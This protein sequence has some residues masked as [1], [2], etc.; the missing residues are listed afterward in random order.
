[1]K[2]VYIIIPGIHTDPADWRN[3]APRMTTAIN[4]RCEDAKADEFR[5]YAL[6]ITPKSRQTE[7]VRYVV[8]LSL[9]YH[10]AGFAV[11]LVAHSNGAII[12]TEAAKIAPAIF[13][14]MHLIAA[15]CDS[16]FSFNGLNAALEK[17]R[18][19]SVCVYTGKKDWVL[20]WMAAAGAWLG[21]G[22]LGYYGPTNVMPHVKHKVSTV[23]SDFGHCGWFRDDQFEATLALVTRAERE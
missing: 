22:Q 3:F 15:A 13:E 20:H 17:G 4:V 8:D 21:Y 6:A 14:S 5:Y 2:R 23:E 7:R 19:G 16:D 11:V 12:A 9:E 1:M 18:V 10:A